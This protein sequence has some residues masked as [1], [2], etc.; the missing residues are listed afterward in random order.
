[1]QNKPLSQFTKACNEIE[2]F[3][4]LAARLQVKLS[5]NGRSETTFKNYIL[6][7]S[8]LSL[9][10]RKLPTLLS[11]H[12]IDNFL[13]VLKTKF[14][15]PSD[16]YF[17]Q[18]VFGLRSL[19]RAEGLTEKAVDLPVLKKSR[20]LPVVLSKQEMARLLRAPLQFKHKFVIAL[21]YGCGL[22]CFE[23]RNLKVSDID[24]DRK[25]LYVSQG[26]GKKDRY[27]PIGDYLSL[28]TELYIELFK[29]EY[30]L[31]N[32]KPE[33]RK[34]GDLGRHYSQSGVQWI[35]KHAAEIAGI[36]KK[37]N[38]HTLRHTFA[39]HLLEDGLDIFS[40]KEM[41]GHSRIETTLVY[42]CTANIDKRN[43]FCPIDTLERL[44]LHSG[45]QLSLSLDKLHS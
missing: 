24:L 23:I 37:I 16:S 18:T 21:L 10:Y 1:M 39:T 7:I 17:K 33:K 3:S 32:G 20:K 25:R 40:V 4:E 6:P 12:E 34:G 44:D 28:L 8:H 19:F 29:P 13:Y 5:I 9:H 15:P 43:N 38:V 27:L 14:N 41:L 11:S 22:R 2:G 30:W 31:F 45:L 42:L 36:K 26:K 35:V